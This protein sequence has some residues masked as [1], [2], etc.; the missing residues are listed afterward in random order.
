MASNFFGGKKFTCTQLAINNGNNGNSALYFSI[1]L[2][3]IEYIIICIKSIIIYFK[4][5]RFIFL[6]FILFIMGLSYCGPISYVINN[7]CLQ[8]F[9]IVS[10]TLRECLK[11]AFAIFDLWPLLREWG[12]NLKIFLDIWATTCNTYIKGPAAFS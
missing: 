3:L 6:L 8:L 5:K 9:L 11:S 4:D 1:K 7:D 2:L 10:T 12:P